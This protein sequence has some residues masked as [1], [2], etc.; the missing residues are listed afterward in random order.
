MRGEDDIGDHVTRERPVS[1]QILEF[2]MVQE[3]LSAQPGDDTDLGP[4]HQAE[5]A[6]ILV[7]EPKKGRRDSTKRQERV[8]RRADGA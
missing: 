8:V 3:A 7:H 6:W 5:K 4:I 2:A 1:E